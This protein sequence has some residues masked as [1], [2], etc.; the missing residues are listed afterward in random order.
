MERPHVAL[1]KAFAFSGNGGWSGWRTSPGTSSDCA[2]LYLMNP[3]WISL[4]MMWRYV[5]VWNYDMIVYTSGCCGQCGTWTPD[6]HKFVL[7]AFHHFC[8]SVLSEVCSL[9]FVVFTINFSMANLQMERPHV[10]LDKALVFSGNGSWIGWRTSAGTSSDC[11]AL[12]L[13]N[14]DWRYVWNYDMIV[15]TYTSGC[16]GHC[17]TW[18]PDVHHLSSMHFIISVKPY[19]Q[20]IVLLFL[21]CLQLTFPWP[22]RRWRDHML[23]WTK[24]LRLRQMWLK[25]LKN[26]P[27]NK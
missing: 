27:R 14:P 13:M 17:G 22:I 1:D 15:Y 24:H 16:C 3:D 7:Y 20:K 11:A 18:T 12:Y 9:S 5:T 26:I 4:N 19:Y 2:A 23:L 6:V 25:W 21:V 8:K 10:P